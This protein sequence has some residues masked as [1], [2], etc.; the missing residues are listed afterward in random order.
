M[1]H[2]NAGVPGCAVTSHAVDTLQTLARMGWQQAVLSA[3]RRDYLIEQVSARGLQ[4]FFTELLGLADIYGVSKVQLGTDYLR[5]TGIDP[6]ACVMSATPTTMPQWLRPSVHLVC[7]TPAGISP[8]PGWKRPVPTSSTTLPSCP[9]CWK[10]YDISGSETPVG[11]SEPLVFTAC[12][13]KSKKRPVHKCVL[14]FLVGAAGFEPTASSSRT[15]RATN[16]AMPRKYR[17]RKA[18]A[19]FWLGMRESNSHK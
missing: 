13:R 2:Y 7:C 4:G 11:V 18:T 15:R 14:V 16:C 5:R 6:A 1:E 10:R 17:S 8:A 12:S 9:H 3:S 19:V